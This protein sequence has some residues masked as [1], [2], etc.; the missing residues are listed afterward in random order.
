MDNN[1]YDVVIIGGSYAGLSAALAL[2]RALFNVLIIDSGRPCN[3]QTPH[4][5]N[6]LTQDGVEPAVIAEKALKQ[7]LIYPGVNLLADKV[8]SV[9]GTDGRFDVMTEGGEAVHAKKLL[10]ATGVRDIMPDIPGLAECWGISVIHCPYC[11]GYEYTGVA[12]GLLANGDEAADHA[13]FLGNWTDNLTVYTNG[14]SVISLDK[15]QMLANLQVKIVE[16]PV[17]HLKHNSGK[18]ESVILANGSEIPISALYV[19][20]PF[21]QHTPVLENIGCRLTK[22]GYIEVDETRQTSVAGI[23]AAGDNMSPM[24]S[25]SGAVASGTMAGVFISRQL[26]TERNLS[27]TRPRV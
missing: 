3:Q 8:I 26:I 7:V 11:H 20:L 27:R 22:Q 2:G 14:E 5:H 13:A 19:R 23:Y 10:F 6:F 15:Q 16:T 21:E 24:R 17:Q 9:A 12:T 18:L 25:V 4:S 1:N